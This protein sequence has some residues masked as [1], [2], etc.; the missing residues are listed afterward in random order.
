M[1]K[2]F[3]L[4]IET[5][6]IDPNTEV[7]LQIAAIEM[8]F[9]K[10]GFWE[11]GRKFEFYQH[12]DRHPVTE[13]AIAHMQDIY[14]HC[15]SVA[16]TPVDQ[17]RQKLLDFFSDCGAKSP[18]VF[19][20]G[21]NVGIFDLP[22]LAHHGYLIPA[23]YDEGV[24]VGDCHYRTYE[25]SGAIQL[26]ANLRG[27]TDVNPIIKEA[28]KRFPAPSEGNRHNALFDCE[29]QINIL[30]GLIQMGH[31]YDAADFGFR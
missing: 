20:C 31:E 14:A 9:S 10:K 29:R 15:N 11:K 27:R 8:N 13:F 21:W 19:I 30:N 6:G 12:T 22:F 18:N 28:E 17:A 4:D 26:V 16:A 3:M 1:K 2:Q 25:I 7:V 24:L 5:T 23:K